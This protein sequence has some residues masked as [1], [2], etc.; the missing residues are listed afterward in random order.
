MKEKQDT[1]APN[2]LISLLISD[3]EKQT[4]STNSHPSEAAQEINKSSEGIFLMV[5]SLLLY[6]LLQN[7]SIK[8]NHICLLVI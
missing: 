7:L 8:L 3:H 4:R 2:V 6:L 1:R 5:L